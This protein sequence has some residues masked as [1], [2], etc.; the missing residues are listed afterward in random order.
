MSTVKDI[1][2]SL[3]NTNDSRYL[4]IETMNIISSDTEINNNEHIVNLTN[5]LSIILKGIILPQSLR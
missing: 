1:D 4:T 3:T 2:S 5:K